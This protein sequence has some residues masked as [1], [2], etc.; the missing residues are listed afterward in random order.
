M[1][2][3]VHTYYTLGQESQAEFTD[4]GSR[5][6]AYA[7]PIESVEAFRLRLKQ[8]K[9]AHPKAVHHCFA[10]RLGTDGNQ[11][12]VS[13]DGEPSGTAGRP[14]LGQIDSR[15]ITNAAVVVV[16]YF[17]GTLLGVPGLIHAYKSAAALAL[18]TTPLVQKQIEVQYQL[19]FDYQRMH[20][21]QLVLRQF[22]CSVHQQELHLFCRLRVGIPRGRL[23]ETLHR[24]Q[25]IY[26][27]QCTP[28]A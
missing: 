17:G 7:F 5:F 6:L 14:I 9:E 3:D 19:E 26:D 23:T 18:Q 1:M 4:R 25:S 15:G 2:H 21:V 16:R 8:L 13:D 22:G 27:L 10:W 28:C 12:R 20:E 11:Y 24:L